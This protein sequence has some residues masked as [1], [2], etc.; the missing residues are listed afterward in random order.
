M[1]NDGDKAALWPALHWQLA[2]IV[3]AVVV[4]LALIL[5]YFD[6]LS[7]AA[8]LAAAVLGIGYVL[9][10]TWRYTRGSKTDANSAG[11]G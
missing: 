8:A 2:G 1:R 11:V 10:L 6:A 5:G 9:L 7:A 4:L 3:C